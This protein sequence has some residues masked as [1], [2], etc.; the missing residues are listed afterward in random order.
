MKKSVVL[1]VSL[2]FN[3]AGVA[4]A[5]L[6]FH[7]RGG[8]D[9][10]RAKASHEH[11]LTSRDVRRSILDGLPIMPGD[12]VLLGDSLL[13]LC[14]WS[15]ILGPK[16]KNRGIAGDTTADVLARMRHIAIDHA[17]RVVIEA[18]IN[19]L[20]FGAPRAEIVANYRKIVEACRGVPVVIVPVFRVNRELY[21][22][23]ILR[24]NPSLHCPTDAEVSALNADLAAL[25]GPGVTVLD[26]HT[27]TP[28][29]MIDGL[30]LDC[31]GLHE[32]ASLIY[33][34]ESSK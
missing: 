22:K 8:V 32:L 23:N 33:Q 31:D 34:L 26:T 12:T 11:P 6:A 21:A 14:E 3:L 13:S 28:E 4:Y 18:G 29:H 24:A 7:Q 17:K 30:H 2:S 25:A 16:Y 10:L 19:D 27:I 20:Q 15:E 1:A 5:A 9:W